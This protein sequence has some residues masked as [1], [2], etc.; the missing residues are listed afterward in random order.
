MTV[1]VNRAGADWQN[2]RVLIDEE[3]RV[4]RDL[5]STPLNMEETSYQRGYIAALNK[6]VEEVE[7]KNIGETPT[8]HYE[9]PS[10]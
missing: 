6:L 5:L 1:H 10:S 8:V 2:L 4:A 3:I 7:P 9:E